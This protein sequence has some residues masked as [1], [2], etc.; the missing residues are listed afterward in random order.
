V[1][2]SYNAP[3]II[4]FTL[5]AAAILLISQL[6]GGALIQLFFR[7]P[8]SREGFA[9]FSMDLLTLISHPLGHVNW[10]HLLSNFSF[11]LLIGP[12]LE[13]KYGSGS[14]LLMMSITAF[15]TGL[16]N[17]LFFSTGLVGASGIVFMFILLISFT[18]FREGEIP[19]TFILVVILFLAKEI[20]DMF[21]PDQISQVAH[22]IGGVCGGLFGFL[23]TPRQKA[24]QN[25]DSTKSL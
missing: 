11:I 16:I 2:I 6:T 1:K 4:T 3:V 7:T 13:E 21:R 15:L 24:K 18:N 17:V 10:E 25:P 19:L 8:S 22:I 12:I 14:L 5:L 23:L 9:F 20:I